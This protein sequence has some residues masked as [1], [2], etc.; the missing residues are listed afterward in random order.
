MRVGF[1][2]LGLACYGTMPTWH[3]AMKGPPWGIERLLAVWWL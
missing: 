2:V 3:C 1:M